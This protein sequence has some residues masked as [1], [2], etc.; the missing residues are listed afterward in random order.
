MSMF[1]PKI[2]INKEK[3]R[4]YLYAGTYVIVLAYSEYVRSFTGEK[5]RTLKRWDLGKVTKT[6]QFFKR[7]EGSVMVEVVF[8]NL[9]DSR[10]KNK[11]GDWEEWQANDFFPVPVPEDTDPLFRD[12][13]MLMRLD[14]SS[15]TLPFTSILAT[16]LTKFPWVEGKT[17]SVPYQDLIRQA[18]YSEWMR[19]LI[20]TT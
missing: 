5:T 11:R 17:V 16:Q 18:T 14:S 9:P 2:S 8:L 6:I 15:P 13:R 1:L 20:G 19:L 3:E 10:K 7:E 12:Y 4:R